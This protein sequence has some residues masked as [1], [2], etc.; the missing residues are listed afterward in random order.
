MFKLGKHD[1]A[2]C[3]IDDIVDNIQTHWGIGTP[4]HINLLL[5]ISM[6]Q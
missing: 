4:I 2:I 3:L 1:D 5:K 6:L